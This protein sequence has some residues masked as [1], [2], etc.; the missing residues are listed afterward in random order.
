MCASA[1][2]NITLSVQEPGIVTI[3]LEEYRALVQKGAMLDMIAQSIRQN[4]DDHFSSYSAVD[5]NLVRWATGTAGYHGPAYGEP[6]RT[7]EG[8]G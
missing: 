1:D 2:A 8:E 6:E 4:I 5:A 7:E 3:S